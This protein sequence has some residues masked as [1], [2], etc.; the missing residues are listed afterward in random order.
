MEVG[1][2]A[3]QAGVEH[4][5]LTVL[6]DVKVAFYQLLLAQRDVELTIQNLATMQEIFQMI[7]ARVDA[8]QA[9]PFEAV[10][11]SVELQKAEKD[12]SRSQNGLIVAR[13]DSRGA[14]EK[15]CGG[16]GLLVVPPGTRVR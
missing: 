10:K 12:L 8:G 5:R 6:S 14:G 2:A 4:T 9:R 15:L 13:D 16:R 3:A 11:A 7:K 1:L